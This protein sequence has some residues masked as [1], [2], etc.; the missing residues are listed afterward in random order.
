MPERM[1]AYVGVADRTD[2]SAVEDRSAIAGADRASLGPETPAER[3][4]NALMI[5]N[6]AVRRITVPPAICDEE[7]IKSGY[8]D[9]DVLAMRRLIASAI[10]QIESR[11]QLLQRNL[12]HAVGQV[13]LLRSASSAP[14]P[15]GI[16]CLRTPDDGGNDVLVVAL[17]DG[18]VKEYRPANEPGD[19]WRDLE[20]VPSTRA[21]ILAEQS[22]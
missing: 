15:R 21:A 14:Q 6:A 7:W 22:E 13:R 5:L 9:E 3:L 19:R 16:T 8:R 18:S 10:E 17:S 11:E 2:P 12:A 4:R 20:P 1:A